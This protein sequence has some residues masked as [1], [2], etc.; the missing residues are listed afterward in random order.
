ML[1]VLEASW[2]YHG[3][4]LGSTCPSWEPSGREKDVGSRALLHQRCRT[5]GWIGPSTAA[6]IANRCGDSKISPHLRV[7]TRGSP[8]IASA[9]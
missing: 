1:V 3:G 4:H 2:D 6:E 5:A 7:H 9:R 8:G